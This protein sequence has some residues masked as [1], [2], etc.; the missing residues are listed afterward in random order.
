MSN[1]VLKNQTFIRLLAETPSHQ[2]RQVLLESAT[3]DQVRALGDI[4]LNI[5]RGRFNKQIEK[6]DKRKR[7]K[8]LKSIL[9]VQKLATKGIAIKEK[10]KALSQAHKGQKGAG[11]FSVLLPLALSTLPALLK[12]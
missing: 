1:C 4:C 9:P 2:Q 10:R 8:F 11:L 6:L 3:P 7:K 5:C 12:K